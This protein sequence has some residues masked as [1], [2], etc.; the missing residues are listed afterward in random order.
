MPPDNAA[1]SMPSIR[2]RLV[3]M[4]YELL[5]AF[6]ALFLPFLVFEFAVDASHAAAVEHGRQALAFFVLGAYFIHQWSRNGQTLAMQTWRL[7]VTQADGTA[8][9]PRRAA[10]RYLLAWM[11]VLPALVASWAFGLEHWHALG[12]IAIGIA[13]WS[14]TAF[15][16]R[17]RQ[18]LHDRIAGTRLVQLPKP[19]KKK[20]P[21]QA[22]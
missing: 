15:L 20:A 22:A 4:V 21:A 11:W 17:D 8:L 3:S 16:D 5:L 14:L 12:A 6:A 18:F 7:R 1:V 2:R 10:L 9:P 19:A 13:L